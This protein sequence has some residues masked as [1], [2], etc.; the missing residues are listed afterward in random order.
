MTNAKQQPVED[1][2]LTEDTPKV[3]WMAADDWG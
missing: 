3:A 1:Q 2:K